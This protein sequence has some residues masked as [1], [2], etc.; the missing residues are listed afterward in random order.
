MQLMLMTV[1]GTTVL[2]LGALGWMHVH[3]RSAVE[4]L[5][6]RIAH[7]LAGVSL[8]TDT[9]ESALRDVATEINRLAST[10]ETSRSRP[11]AATQ[12]RIAGA[13]QRGTT[14]QNI[15]ATE[16]MSEGEV[17]LRLQLDKAHKER[18]NTYASM[19]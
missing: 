14:V 13:A 2:V 12:R 9:T 3:H 17:R 5:D 7:L 6:D 19:R 11:R 16:E 18:L 4:R 10:S 1:G 8:L 15:A